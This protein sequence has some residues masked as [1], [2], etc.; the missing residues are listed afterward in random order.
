MFTMDSLNL[1]TERRE[2]EKNMNLELKTNVNK[3]RDTRVNI[4]QS[5]LPPADQLKFETKKR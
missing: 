4:F 2:H 5:R 3:K 1:L